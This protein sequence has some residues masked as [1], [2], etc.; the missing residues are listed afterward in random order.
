MN[1]ASGGVWTQVTVLADKCANQSAI[2]ENEVLHDDLLQRTTPEGQLPY[3]FK[4][5]RRN[6]SS[7]RPSSEIG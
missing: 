3:V 4:E 7:L 1:P 5:A 2:L 6:I